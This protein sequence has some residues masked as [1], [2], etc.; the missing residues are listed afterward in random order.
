MSIDEDM[1]TA[2]E[3][4]DEA[5]LV[6]N[7]QD[8]IEVVENPQDLA[9]LERFRKGLDLTDPKGPPP[10]FIDEWWQLRDCDDDDDPTYDP[11]VEDTGYGT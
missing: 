2:A 7:S 4:E 10:G 9:L 6:D 8:E 5:M 1:D 11:N 3:E